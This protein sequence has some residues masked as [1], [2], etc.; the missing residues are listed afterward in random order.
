MAAII[1][2][3]IRILNAN[4]FISLANDSDNNRFYAFLGLVNPTDYLSTWD[5]NP[6]SP[7][8][9][10]EQESDFWDT[11]VAMKRISND[12]IRQ[13]IR[14][15]TW[16]SGTTYD[17]YRNDI[18]RNNVAKPSNATNL[19]ASNYYVMN[20]DYRVY[21]CLQ[22]GTT[23]ETPQGKP[24]LDEPLFTDLEPR[25]AGDSGDGYVWKYLYT[26]KPSDI[27]KFDS[28]NFIPVPKNWDT[29]PVHDP[30]R[31]NAQT[32]G[33]IKI[34]TITNRGVGLGT[35]GITYTDIPIKGDGSGAKAT[36]VVNNDAKVE[37][38][39]VSDGGFGYTHG[40][41]DLQSTTFPIG[42][43]SPEFDVIIPPTG[44]HGND[45][46]RELGATN[47]LLYTRIENDNENPDFIVGNQIARVGIVRN[48]VVAGSSDTLL[49]TDKVSALYALKLTGI[50]YSSATFES[51][52]FITQT[53]GVGSTAVGRV[54]SYDDATGVLKY[55]QDKSIVGFNSDGTQRVPEYG[56]NLNRFT[57]DPDDGGDLIIRGGSV[58]LQI[59]SG[60]I[61]LTTTINNKTY[62]LG[63]YFESGV[64]GPEVKKY[65]GEIIYV[66]NRPSITRSKSQKEDIKVILQF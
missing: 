7:R 27:V 45:I 30:I 48:P 25:S 65:S 15:I 58:N 64:S 41:V 20:S 59:D 26:I 3:Q 29:D 40:R 5:V 6:P 24:S 35:G 46:Y 47:I 50:G 18:S 56:Y 66:D 57:A 36:I 19:Y 2:D 28:V 17:M 55:W 14:K 13:V 1:T 42:T 22:N 52:G 60:F 16:N 34:I 4:N 33:Q 53:V 63:Q 44:G 51:D 23:P 38:I 11:M 31:Q 37:S 43:D 8:D 39:F 10:F 54:V 61:G 21:I 12:D 49:N 9:S 32:S 62:N